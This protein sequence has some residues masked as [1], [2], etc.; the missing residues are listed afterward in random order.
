MSARIVSVNVSSEKG[1]KKTPVPGVTLA[2]GIGVTGDAHAGTARQISMLASEAVECTGLPDGELGPGAFGENITTSGIDLTSMKIGQRLQLGSDAI[3]QISQKGKICETPCSIGRRLGECIMP[4]DGVFAKVLVGGTIA[5]GDAIEL[6]TMKTGAVI[7]SSDRCARGERQDESGPA[8]VQLLG[9][10]GLAVANYVVMPDDE[11]ELA[12]RLVFLA[13][14]CAADVVLTTGGTGF[15]L[16]DRMPEATLSV[17]DTPVPGIAEAIR[18]EGLQH[19]PFAC[20]S[21]GLSGLRGR[22]LIVNLPGSRKAISQTAD[23]LRAAL[24]HALDAL[25]MEVIDCGLQPTGR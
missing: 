19:T 5:V 13:D 6:T 22:T 25:R 23:L 10:M 17:L 11:A 8:L 21:R 2:S 3:V 16:R 15:S 4:R 1:E 12:Q 20:I 7:T 9:G 24:P 14:C 18:H